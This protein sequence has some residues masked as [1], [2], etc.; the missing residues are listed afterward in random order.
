M[1]LVKC[2]GLMA[3][4]AVLAATGC[5]QTGSVVRGQ[6]PAGGDFQGPIIGTA[7]GYGELKTK[8]KRSHNDY[9]AFHGH[10]NHVLGHENGQY[11]GSEAFYD[12]HRKHV[13]ETGD[14]GGGCPACNN[15]MSCPAG[16]CPHCG[17][18]CGHDKPDHYQTYSYK[19]PQNL[20]YP[21][22]VLPAGM[23]QYPYYT[24]RGPTDFFMK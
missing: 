12:N 24:L 22:P 4:V 5:T 13:Y 8:A 18:G 16:G 7:P 14:G 23:V 15:G 21:P 19:W 3:G 11:D 20:A 6:S 17:C 10:R 9:K 2:L 1:N